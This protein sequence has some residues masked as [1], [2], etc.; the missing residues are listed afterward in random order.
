MRKMSSKRWSSGSLEGKSDPTISCGV[1]V[2]RCN[3]ISILNNIST[4]SEGSLLFCLVKSMTILR[5][6]FMEG[7]YCFFMKAHENERWFF[8]RIVLIPIPQCTN[9]YFLLIYL[10][11]NALLFA[12]LF[13][14]SP[15]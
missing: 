15:F 10:T 9:H 12:Q 7:P 14:I 3:N 2:L 6:R 13:F 8:G 11:A 4:T 5:F 1:D